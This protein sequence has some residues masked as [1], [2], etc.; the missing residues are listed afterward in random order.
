MMFIV[1]CR[2]LVH[3]ISIKVNIHTHNRKPHRK[4]SQEKE[5]TTEKNNKKR[6]TRFIVGIC[7]I[8]LRDMLDCYYISESM[9]QA[10]LTTADE[11]EAVS[12]GT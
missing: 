6:Y 2:P 12:I 7:G 1:V 3:F 10:T 8:R 4:R 11:D 5:R 9:L